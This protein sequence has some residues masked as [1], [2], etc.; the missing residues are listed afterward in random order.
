VAAA[1][2]CNA[3]TNASGR[4]SLSRTS[5]VAFQWAWTDALSA[6]ARP[7]GASS[8]ALSLRLFLNAWLFAIDVSL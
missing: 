3:C 8:L 4:I 2:A 1:L 5:V 6:P 7:R